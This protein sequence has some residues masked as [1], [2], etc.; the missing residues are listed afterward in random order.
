MFFFGPGVLRAF[1]PSFIHKTRSNPPSLPGNVCAVEWRLLS[2][3]E[4][5]QYSGGLTSVLWRANIST[6]EVVQYSGGLTSV[7][8]RANIKYSGGLTSVLWRANISTVE[9][10]QYSG[11]LTSVQWRAN[12]KYSGGLTSC[13][14]RVMLAL[15][16]TEQP[17][18]YCTDI[19]RGGNQFL[20]RLCE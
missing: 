17:P 5:A 7:Q 10:V 9:V 19:I 1:Q 12:I 2:R 13:V 6:V 8:W 18:L 4:A 16:C 15:H 20:H 3:V 11:G 14:W